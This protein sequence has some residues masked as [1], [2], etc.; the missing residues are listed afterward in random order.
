MPDLQWRERDRLGITSLDAQHEGLFAIAFR[1]HDA[2]RCQRAMRVQHEM[3]AQFMACSRA[4]VD[5]EERGMRSAG[6]PDFARHQRLH[7]TFLEHLQAMYAAVQS[8]RHD[9]MP[10]QL[11]ILRVWMREHVV[12]EDARYAFWIQQKGRLRNRMR[13][14]QDFEIQHK[15]R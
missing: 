8:S 5:S 4:H 2:M 3:L 10:E 13:A 9:A 11:R 14:R 12:N 15:E 1:L 6:Y 7:R